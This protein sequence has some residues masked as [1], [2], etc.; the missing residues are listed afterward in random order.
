[1]NFTV[2]KNHADMIICK[3][4]QCTARKPG[5]AARAAVKRSVIRSVMDSACIGMIAAIVLLMAAS[6]FFSATETAYSSLNRIR[7]KNRAEAEERHAALALKIAN[8]YERLLS[9]VLIGNNIVNIAAASV[10]TV[11]FT[12]IL[13][14]RGEVYGPTVSTIVLTLAILFFSEVGPKKLAKDRPEDFAIRVAPPISVLMKIFTPLN[15]V[16]LKW[17]GL[18]GK[19][20][21]TGEEEGITEEELITMVSEAENEGGLDEDESEL[22]R[23][24]IEFNDQTVDM[25]LTPRVDVEAVPDDVSEDELARLFIETGYSRLPVYHG[26]I[27]NIIG[28]IHEKDF[29]YRRY[30]GRPYDVDKMTSPVVYTT[31]STEISELLHTLQR[32]KNHLA[33]VVDEYGGTEGIVT[34][35]DILEELV[36]EIW[37][38]HD[39]VVEMFRK[40][41][42]GSYLID[43]TADLDDMFELFGIREDE[44]SDSATV[45]GWVMEQM[46]RL[47]MAGDT[48][49]FEDL[50]V[51]V[52]KTSGRRPALIRVVVRSEDPEI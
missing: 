41:S 17:Q 45:S 37:D 42:D 4:Y 46:G 32:G 30:K 28:V 9:S 7:L 1:M 13:L 49:I 33:V 50:K 11:L 20:F 43:C 5:Q 48:F 51:T 2:S 35:E 23:A 12:R 26:T 27:D 10:G 15:F 6:A 22:I 34:L 29:Y 47:P 40:Q 8:D 24:A 21:H 31:V 14:S 44:E 16:L 36:G 19:V 3:K 25:I 38:E 39:E 52:V 18:V